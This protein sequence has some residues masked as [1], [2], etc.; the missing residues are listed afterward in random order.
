MILILF[1]IDSHRG[2]TYSAVEELIIITQ[3]SLI[4]LISRRG[5]EEQDIIR[6]RTKS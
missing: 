2:E 5:G 6:I 1:I 4:L 3:W